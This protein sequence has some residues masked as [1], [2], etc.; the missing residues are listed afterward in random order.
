VARERARGIDGRAENHVTR[1]AVLIFVTIM[2]LGAVTVVAGRFFGKSGS[3]A[4]TLVSVI[5]HWLAAYVLWSFA[6][7]L[8]VRHGLLEVYHPTVFLLLAVIAGTWHYRVQVRLG[9]EQGR[10]VFVG[11]QLAWLG[12][13]LAENGLFRN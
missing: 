6:G 12:I 5:A 1:W 11:C 2:A 9:R 13:L 7:G 8:A 3:R 4:S 10:M